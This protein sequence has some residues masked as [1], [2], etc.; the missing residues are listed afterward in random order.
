MRRRLVRST[1]A[2]VV[3]AVVLLGVPLAV[4][5]VLL[6]RESAQLAMSAATATLTRVVER[7]SDEGRP[8]TAQAVADAVGQRYHASVVLPGGLVVEAG[9]PPSGSAFATAHTSWGATVLV[10]QARPAA[11]TGVVR[12]LLLVA[13]AALVAVAAAV[14][15][16][17]TQARRLSA[18]LD[19][20]VEAAH[21]LGS[22][23]PRLAYQRVG[24]DELDRV[25]DVLSTSAGRIADMLAAERRLAAEASHQLRTPLTALTLRLEEIAA[26]DDLD[27]ARE[28]ARIAATQV[29]RL[30]S[31]VERLLATARRGSAST[32][33]ALEV[34][35][36]LDQQA[37][38]WRP[39]FDAAGR[40]LVVE[41]MPGL[42]V[43]ATRGTLA[44]VLAA[45]IENSLTH[46]GGTVWVRTRVSS[47]SVVVE[48]ADEGPGV[49]ENLGASVLERSVS[50][51][52]GTGLGLALA[53]DLVEADGGRLEL[54]SSRPATFALFLPSAG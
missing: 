43:L 16:G 24:I 20:L 14:A 41:G 31:V 15:V 10:R 1:L 45:L 11:S 51:G 22:G 17:L 28:E 44:Q 50:G 42:H 19:A 12:V 23:G 38:E 37:K 5:G 26:T 48:V 6:Q 46:G 3:V 8:L 21:R 40:V 52:R 2:V 33:A 18:P 53:R 9:P 32:A 7:S 47:G 54:V 49:P 39:A 4:A 25:G 29:E 13:G 35:D 30:T 27:V 34:D 36:V